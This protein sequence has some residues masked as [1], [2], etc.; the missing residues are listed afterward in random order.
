M[1]IVL[2]A[3]SIGTNIATAIWLLPP[4]SSSS[5]NPE[6]KPSEPLETSTP[7][8]SPSPKTTPLTSPKPSPSSWK[9]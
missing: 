5:N 6:L 9:K 4:K 3:I 8:V 1:T 7:K 2:V